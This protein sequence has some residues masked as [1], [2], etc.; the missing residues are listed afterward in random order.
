MDAASAQTQ[1]QAMQA[2]LA[3]LQAYMPLYFEVQELLQSTKTFLAMM[4]AIV[5]FVSFK[6]MS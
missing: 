4:T 6:L 2:Q 1:L 5:V 3:Q